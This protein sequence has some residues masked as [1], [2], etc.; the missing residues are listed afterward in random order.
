MEI[1]NRDTKILWGLAAGQCSFPGCRMQLIP[2]PSGSGNPAVIG[3]MAHIVDKDVNGPRGKSPLTEAQRN[4]YAN[5]I[6]LC[7][8]HHT[9]IDDQEQA[10]K[11]PIELLHEWKAQHEDW[12][13]QNRASGAVDNWQDEHY[14]Y[15]VDRITD[16]LQLDQ[17]NKISELLVTD[18]VPMWLSLNQSDLNALYLGAILPGTRP[19]IE[20]AIK[21]VVDS[22]G[23]Y[24]ENFDQRA[25]SDISGNYL[26]ADHSFYQ[27][28][29]RDAHRLHEEEDKEHAWSKRNGEL[30]FAFVASLNEFADT[31]R[32]ELN[33][34]YLLSNGRFLLL[35]PLGYRG[36]T[37]QVILPGGS[38]NIIQAEGKTNKGQP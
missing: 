37:S 13:R 8:N 18:K 14:A 20:A 30:L 4:S 35:D 2:D 3:E 1:S 24:L 25:T 11:Y 17:W 7:P 27:W 23:Q 33:P 29:P 12:V 31:V 10:A 19:L 34:R 26:V 5:L 38:K 21:E 32:A 36:G 6:L 22:F 16:V 15:L 9:L 28:S